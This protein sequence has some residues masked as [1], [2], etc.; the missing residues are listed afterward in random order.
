M[1]I[2]ILTLDAPNQNKRI[3]SRNVVENE[4]NRLNNTLIKEKQFLVYSYQSELISENLYDAVG[5]VTNLEIQDNM[6][7]ADVEFLNINNGKLMESLVV[8]G[9]ACICVSGVGTINK[10]PNNTYV[11]G[12]DYKLINLYVDITNK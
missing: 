9:D 12:E 7:I 5:I 4:I 10:L 1:K 6:V 3:Y 8:G 11:V 2:P